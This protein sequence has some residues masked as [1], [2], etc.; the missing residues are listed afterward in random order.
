ME[1]KK[2]SKMNNFGIFK[3]SSRKIIFSKPENSSNLAIAM[4]FFRIA[5]KKLFFMIILFSLLSTLVFASVPQTF[6]IQGRLTD[7]SG[8]V[9]SGN[10]NMSFGIYSVASGGSKLWEQNM[11]VAA[12]SRGIYN[13]IL[14]DVDVELETTINISGCTNVSGGTVYIDFDVPGYGDNYINAADYVSFLWKAIL[15]S[16]TFSNG[17]TEYNLTFSTDK[18]NHTNIFITHR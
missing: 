4:Q 18:T 2:M 15:N 1:K 10:Y 11:T 13:V 8:S 7:S 17:A 16:N 3:N 5:S 9:L 14:S 6:N 12:D